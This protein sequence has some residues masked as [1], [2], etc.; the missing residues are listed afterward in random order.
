MILKIK[1]LDKNGWVLIDGIRKVKFLSIDTKQAKVKSDC[2]YIVLAEE[3]RD[4]DPAVFVMC[5]LRNDQEYNVVFNTF[6][7]MLSDEGKT[8]E[9]L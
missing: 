8:I 2:N 1:T 6:G 5:S 4:E 7:F 9:R 3:M